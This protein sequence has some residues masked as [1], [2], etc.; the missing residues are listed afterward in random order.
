MKYFGTDGFRGVANEVLTPEL[1]F[2]IGRYIGNSV[3][4]KVTIVIGKDSR[5]S[6]DMLEYALIAGITSSGGDVIRVG[7]IPT[8]AVT[9]LTSY[10][11]ANYGIIISASHNPVVDNG[12]KIVD[13]NGTKISETLEEEI[14]TFIDSED[15]MYRAKA[16]RI[17]R[18]RYEDAAVSVYID[19]LLRSTN[20]D[21]KGLK[22]VVDAANGAASSVV[23][24]L[25]SNYQCDVIYINNEPN[26]LNIND[27]CGST[28]PEVLASTVVSSKADL[29]FALDGDA[30][31]VIFVDHEGNVVDG[32]ILMYILANKYKQEGKLRNDKIALTVMSNLG[33]V[34]AL[35]ANLGVEVVTTSVGDKYV[36]AALNKEDL[37]LGGESSGHIILKDLSQC[38]DGLL[39]ALQIMEYLYYNEVKLNNYLK[40]IFKFPSVLINVRV[41]DKEYVITHRN[42][43][44][45]IRRVENILA[46][47]GR[48]LVRKSG[49]EEL[50][51]VLVEC[52]DKDDCIYY[53]NSIVETIKGVG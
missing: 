15:E 6:C 41:V 17:G 43:E 16:G 48:V 8:P 36:A 5:I 40:N 24:K 31:R 34:K 46:N 45:E 49:T 7:V 32:D 14:E 27:N 1:A 47:S 26:G 22:I 2:K 23:E 29:G 38:G 25:F 21:L 37:V 11:G 12:I 9:F 3:Q 13:A 28:C 18:V 19:K 51:R 53:A 33:V 10:Y 30:D 52:E 20:S 44:E 4:S 35:E 39:V 50:I 42:V